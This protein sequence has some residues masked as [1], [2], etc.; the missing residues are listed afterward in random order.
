MEYD[1]QFP[2]TKSKKTNLTTCTG[3][4]VSELVTIKKK[5][6]KTQSNIGLSKRKEG[7]LLSRAA[8]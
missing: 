6:K 4:Q 7:W 2:K 3:I 1:R 8:C 5:K